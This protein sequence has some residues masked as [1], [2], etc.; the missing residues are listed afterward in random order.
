M[1]SKSNAAIK[2]RNKTFQKKIYEYEREQK[3]RYEETED[4]RKLGREARQSSKRRE[5]ESKTAIIERFLDENVYEGEY[6]R[7]TDLSLQLSGVD[8]IY[9]DKKIDEKFS[10]SGWNKD[11][12]TFNFEIYGENNPNREGWLWA[13]NS[14]TTHYNILWFRATDENLSEIV[15]YTLLEIPKAAL[16]KYL[17]CVG[18]NKKLLNDFIFHFDSGM[19]NKFPYSENSEKTCRYMQITDG[20]KLVQNTNTPEKSIN[21]CLS[22]EILLSLATKMY[23]QIM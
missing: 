4:Q 2:R 20:V 6:E 9:R 1:S 15:T 16:L 18:V 22:R 19:P 11:T 21:V 7:V 5:D 12:T 8:L 3:K 14:Q 23:R 10:I 13:S 17:N